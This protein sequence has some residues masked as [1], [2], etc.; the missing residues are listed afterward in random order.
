MPVVSITT[1]ERIEPVA[2]GVRRTLLVVV[3]IDGVRY[4]TEASDAKQAARLVMQATR[5][6]GIARGGVDAA[7]DVPP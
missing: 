2:G 6:L 4:V 1:A 5:A 7:E 3:T